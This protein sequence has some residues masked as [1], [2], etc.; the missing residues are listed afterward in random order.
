M[1]L[2][3]L[4]SIVQFLIQ[5]FGDKQGQ[6]RTETT[7]RSYENCA[8]TAQKSYRAFAV[9]L[10]RLHGDGVVAVPL[11]CSLGQLCTKS[12]QLHISAYVVKNKR[13]DGS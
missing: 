9:S 7:Q 3:C 6:T 2:H 10:R 11:S 12:I 13:L 8:V 5:A 1:C 4:L